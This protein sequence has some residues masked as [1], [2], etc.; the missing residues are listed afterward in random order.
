MK[1]K[2]EDKKG[3]VK[4]LSNTLDLGDQN[5]TFFAPEPGKKNDLINKTHDIKN[6]STSTKKKSTKTINCSEFKAN[7]EKKK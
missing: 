5:V 6:K 2:S 3:H 1:K 4:V 7:S